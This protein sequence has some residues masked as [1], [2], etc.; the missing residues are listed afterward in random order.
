M[1]K[2]RDLIYNISLEFGLF[3]LMPFIIR[4][5]EPYHRFFLRLK[6][7][8]RFSI[9]SYRAYVDRPDLKRFAIKNIADTLGV[10]ES[11]ARGKLYRLMQLEVFAERNGFLLDVYTASDLE[12]RFTIH[13]IELLKAEL[14][15]GKG[16]IFATVHSG[17]ND[18]FMLFLSLKRYNIYG[19][20][21]GNIQY[22]KINNPLEKFA[23]L[24]DHKITGKIGKIYTGKGMKKLFDVL[25]GD[26][27]IV[28]MVDLPSRN[29]KRKTTVDFLGKKI[30]VDNSFWETA[31]KTG[32]SLVPYMN[33]Y[34]YR[35]DRHDI[36]VGAPVDFN[37]NSIQDLFCFYEAYVKESPESWIGWYIFDMLTV[38]SQMNVKLL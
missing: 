33:I 36:Y 6:S 10:D 22:K 20:Y 15:K 17:E 4:L 14:K 8:L 37:K 29:I 5:P 26:N 1:K 35:K 16:V 31:L 19:L 18:L 25:K 3:F 38:D 21:D 7:Y 23:K 32:A 30:A 12:N 34:D 9:G 11:V 2:L 28:W 13:G 24:K 27:I